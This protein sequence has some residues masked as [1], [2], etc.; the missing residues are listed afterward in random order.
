M[1][2]HR[3]GNSEGGEGGDRAVQKAGGRREKVVGGAKAGAGLRRVVML[4]RG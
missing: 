3:R 2:W 4:P 1:R